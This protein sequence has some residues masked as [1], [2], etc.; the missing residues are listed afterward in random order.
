AERST[1]RARIGSL[2]TTETRLRNTVK[3]ERKARARIERH[4]GLVQEDLRQSK[5]SRR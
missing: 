4:L 3:D 2:E 5:M 1:L